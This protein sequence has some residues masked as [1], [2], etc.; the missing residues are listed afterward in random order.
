MTRQLNRRW[1]R[2]PRIALGFV[3][4]VGALLLGACG[5]AGTSSGDGKADPD[6]TLRLTYAGVQ[7]LDPAKSPGSTAVLSNT[8]P[9]YDR[10]IQIS[11]DGEYLPMLATKWTFSPDGKTLRLDL[12]EGV[13]FSDGTPFTA[14]TVKAN[15]ERYRAEPVSKGPTSMI[16]SVE[17]V[18]EHTVALHLAAAS[19]AVLG[20]LSAS[21]P[22]IMIS[23][24][25]LDNPDLTTKPVGSGAWVIDGFRPGESVSYKRRT[26]KG[27]IWD[28]ETGKVAG[29]EIAVRSTQAAYAAIRSGQVDVVLSNGDVSELQTGIDQGTLKMRPLKNASTTAAVYFNRTMKP[30]DDL[31]LRQAV[32]YAINRKPLVKALL[33]TTTARVQPLAS[34]V[35]GFDESLESAYPY[36]PAKA[37]QLV[38]AAGYP[39][40]VDGGTFYV[41]NWEPFPDAAQ[42]VQADLAKVGIRIKLEL[43]DIRQ[44]STGGYGKANKPGAINFMSY[45]GLEPGVDLA[46]FLNNPLTMPGGVPADI[47]KQIAAI[48]DSTAS[49]EERASRAG[50][51]VKWATDNAMYAPLWQG[52]PGWVMTDKVHGVESGKAFLAPLGGQDFRYA[53][54]SK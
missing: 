19:R 24:K 38:A 12:R 15:L 44:L 50:A 11:E 51:V 22:G 8:W 9:V 34:V 32:N 14:S 48:D 53:W 45:P 25:A 2:G 54:M 36:D 16:K 3:L 5:S 18:D 21:A 49:D 47:V 28:P 41:A 10:L 27:G 31:R 52:V 7:S 30:F 20:A 6:A 4:G 23:E 46:W 1:A 26:D 37:K 43:M 29:I 42:I 33:P 35:T 13:T 39:D 17:I 40:G